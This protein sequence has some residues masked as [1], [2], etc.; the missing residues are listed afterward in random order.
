MN[1]RQ[2]EQK[3][4]IKKWVSRYFVIECFEQ[5][6]VQMFLGGVGERRND[7]IEAGKGAASADADAVCGLGLL[8]FR[9]V[10]QHDGDV[11]A[12]GIYA[13]TFL[14]FETRAV[15]RKADLLFTQ[16]TSKNFEKL[17]ADSHPFLPGKFV[18]IGFLT[19]TYSPYH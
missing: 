7:P 14:A 9:F 3:K 10:N 5:V 8:Y 2:N 1:N 19:R 17:F 12:D 18:R 13:V 16:G 15:R 6:G 11:V 4:L